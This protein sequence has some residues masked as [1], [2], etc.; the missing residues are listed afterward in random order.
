[1]RLGW[2]VLAILLSVP[3]RGDEV[4][5]EAKRHFDAGFVAY[6]LQRYSEALAHFQDAYELKPDPAFLYN[7]GQCQRLLG[8]RDAA[9]RSYLS[10]LRQVPDAPNREHVRQLV[11]E[12]RAPPAAPPVAPAVPQA[13][14][15]AVQANATAATA[16]VRAPEPA[17]RR[18]PWYR[19]TS[20]VVVSSIGLA[21]TAAGAA[22]L[23]VGAA[24]DSDSRAA[25]TIA[26]QRSDWAAG[27][28]MQ[29]AGIATISI[30]GA[31][32]IIG[33][34]LFATTR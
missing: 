30:G 20:A 28:T 2:L 13:R 31:A 33:G 22:L 8:Q 21:A 19:R 1:M 27:G 32:L 23:V 7:I 15:A 17:P 14:V 16:I 9:V 10:Y 24:D 26:E 3:A 29:T 5:L 34:I 11:D 12:L 6:D 25:H 4:A 18:R